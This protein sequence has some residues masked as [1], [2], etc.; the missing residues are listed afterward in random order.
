MKITSR[1]FLEGPKSLRINETPVTIPSPFPNAVAFPQSAGGPVSL[2]LWKWRRPPLAAGTTS[3]KFPLWP[4]RL[5]I[6]TALPLTLWVVRKAVGGFHADPREAPRQREKSLPSEITT[7]PWIS[8]RSLYHTHACHSIQTLPKETW[9]RPA[10]AAQ[11]HHFL[12][13]SK[14]P[15]VSDFVWMS[16]GIPI[17]AVIGAI[18][19][20]GCFQLPAESRH[21]CKSRPPPLA[22]TSRLP[23]VLKGPSTSHNSIPNILAKSCV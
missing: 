17:T 5:W 6:S 10:K 19:V 13:G 14:T 21:K 18:L 23:G 4:N 16:E 1:L 15:F 11:G 12:Q 9:W 20:V 3:S 22:T 2:F 8:V 7:I